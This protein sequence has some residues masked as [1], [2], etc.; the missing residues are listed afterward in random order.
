MDS[1][2][3]SKLLDTKYDDGVSTSGNIRY[4]SASSTRNY[5]YYKSIPMPN[6]N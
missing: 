1:T 5:L 4:G 2:D 3:L 6:P